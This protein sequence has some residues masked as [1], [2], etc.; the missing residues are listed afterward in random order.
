MWCRSNWPKRL[1]RC[2]AFVVLAA[3]A[4]IASA[5]E[6]APGGS[7]ADVVVNYDPFA[8]NT[9][10]GVLDVELEN[11]GDVECDVRLTFTTL[12]GQPI[13]LV[14]IGGIEL[15]L[16]PRDASGSLR[17]ES[18]PGSFVFKLAAHS[19]GRAEFDAIIL[20]D[21]VTEAGEQSVVLALNVRSLEGV[22]LV[23]QRP[24]NLKLSTARRAQMNIAGAAGAFG[25]GG[26]VAEI[27]FGVLETGKSR[28][29][30]LQVR[31][32]SKTELTVSSLNHGFLKHV[33]QGDTA[34]ISYSVLLDGRALDLS[35]VAV[36]TLDLPLTIEGRS[37]S[38]DF[39]LGEVSGPPGRYEDILT[40]DVAPL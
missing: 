31:A 21:A 6:L 29:I 14:T 28:R 5:C 13:G 39:V 16:K 10:H 25:S 32:N 20:K 22:S 1:L 35:A 17:A 26:T 36:A 38:L 23:G 12:G 19:R 7:L 27:D 11:V 2:C 30:F 34:L 37:S 24:F 33:G 15:T 4:G 40:V 8:V 9:A 18:G 3:T